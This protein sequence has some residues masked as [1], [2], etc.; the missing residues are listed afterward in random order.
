MAVKGPDFSKV[1]AVCFD[2]GMTLIGPRK[3]ISQLCA[4]VA[5]RLGYAV[6]VEDVLRE[7]ADAN[8]LY[9]NF[10]REDP[11]TWSSEVSIREKWRA[12]Y[13]LI[14]WRLGLG[15][16]VDAAAQQVYD[17]FNS[18]EQWL[19]FP[20]VWPTLETLKRRGYRIGVV[21]DWGT[22]LVD[23]LLLPLGLAPYLDTVVVSA[24]VGLAK[25]SS[26]LYRLAASRF[27]LGPEQ[28]IHVGDS[29]IHDV[30]GARSAGMEGVL[31]DR[32][33]RTADAELDC[34]RISDLTQML[35][36]VP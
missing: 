25:P 4:E 29:Y 22:R 30:L 18:V 15:D 35:S 34:L 3:D 28:V 26:E 6:T 13:S 9:Q 32:E 36:L 8:D 20:D 27:G 21:S 2:A 16:V 24:R 10:I 17:G 33:H 12:Y 1:S 5:S 7:M 31:V 11:Q 14:F 23:A 19:V